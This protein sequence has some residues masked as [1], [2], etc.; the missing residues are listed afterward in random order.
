MN[1]GLLRSEFG[2]MLK[3]VI[4][5]SLRRKDSPCPCITKS[6]WSNVITEQARGSLKGGRYNELKGIKSGFWEDQKEHGCQCTPDTCPCT[7]F[8]MHTVLSHLI[9]AIR[10]LVTIFH[11]TVWLR[12]RKH[13]MQAH[14]A[15]S[16][17][18]ASNPSLSKP[19]SLSFSVLLDLY[20][21]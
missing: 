10:T 5:F 2:I 11:C 14:T 6:Q 19:K 7:V 8:G 3:G 20:T 13:S 1:L 17:K 12:K 15:I 18:L 9:L 4:T 16:S 21:G